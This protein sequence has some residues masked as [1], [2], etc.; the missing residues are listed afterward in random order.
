MSA[1]VPAPPAL[2][3]ELHARYQ[4]LRVLGQGGM[5]VVIL[6]R[7]LELDALVAVKLLQGAASGPAR[8]R[9]H[10]EATALAAVRHENVLE[11][12]QHGETREG[13]YLVTAHVEGVSLDQADLRADLEPVMMSLAR[14]LQ[15]VHQAGL[16]H[17]DLKPANVLLTPQRRPVLI[18]FGLVADPQRT[19][20]TA[21][22]HLVGTLLFLAPEV[23]CGEPASPSSD[24]YSWAATWY[25][26]AEGTA[27]FSS[28]QLIQA[29]PLTLPTPTFQHLDPE[30]PQARLLIRLLT[31]RVGERPD[32]LERIEACLST[33]ARPPARPPSPAPP[34]PVPARSRL[35]PRILLFLA[36]CLG[37]WLGWEG[38]ASPPPGP[39]PTEEA[40]APQP[41]FPL[42]K[43][44]AARI[45]ADFQDLLEMGVDP[46]EDPEAFGTLLRASKDLRGFYEW[47]ATGGHPEVLSP[48]DRE[49]L[50]GLSIV[51]ESQG[52]ASPLE[53]FLS[54]SP[55]PGSIETPR[56]VGEL[57]RARF[58]AIQQIPKSV[59]GWLA[60][61]LEAA[62]EAR[63]DALAMEQDLLSP[64]GGERL[65]GASMMEMTA[66]DWMAAGSPL[67]PILTTLRARPRRMAT[68]CSLLRPATGKMLLFLYAGRRSLEEEPG[69]SSFLALLS[70]RLCDDFSLLL[71]DSRFLLLR[72][73]LLGT[74]PS[75][76]AYLFRGEILDEQLRSTKLP[77]ILAPPLIEE[78]RAAWE[79]ARRAT[80]EDSLTWVLRGHALKH[81]LKELGEEQPP[82]QAER[83]HAC[84][85]SFPDWNR[86]SGYDISEI[87]AMCSPSSEG[88]G[89]R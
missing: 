43:G 30:S 50:S 45:Q 68:L 29:Q 21:T 70:V 60:T 11:V 67:S 16:I 77:S 59:S 31:A 23:L 33:A 24:W 76:E 2:P 71:M 36:L 85:E 82:R 61:A 40:P 37:L 89:P 81:I 34:P 1:S 65:L 54:A 41:A 18:D 88:S 55:R 57:M 72:S 58:P 46:S 6:A 74:H 20:L 73:A 87:R 86:F 13:P 53:P 22:G 35:A 44:F 27:P 12:F 56:W 14:G 66:L 62:G 75:S 28:D 84:Q 19:R 80:A 15:A 26:L 4:A 48:V 39:P 32:S 7:D 10:R 9:F 78:R 42:P 69:T 25:C 79:E 3:E 49:E 5:G 64:G 47:M 63:R 83:R 38:R 52:L 17:R 8:T 51:L